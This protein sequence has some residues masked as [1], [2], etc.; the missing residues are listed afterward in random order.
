MIKNVLIFL[1]MELVDEKGKTICF[2]SYEEASSYINQKPGPLTQGELELLAN[3]LRHRN[4]ENLTAK[5]TSLRGI[6][7]GTKTDQAEYSLINCILY[8]RRKRR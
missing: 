4:T 6:E 8:E 2:N 1:P 3:T 7:R 5:R